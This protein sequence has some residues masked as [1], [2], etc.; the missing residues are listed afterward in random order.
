MPPSTDDFISLMPFD[1]A[2]CSWCHAMLGWGLQ[3]SGYFIEM[4]HF[5]AAIDIFF[6][7][8]SAML[9]IGLFSFTPCFRRWPWLVY[10]R[11]FSILPLEASPLRYY[12]V[13]LSLFREAIVAWCGRRYASV[14][15]LSL[16]LAAHASRVSCATSPFQISSAYRR[17]PAF[18]PAC[19]SFTTT[20]PP[21]SSPHFSSGFIFA[22]ATAVFF[23]RRRRASHELL[24][25]FYFSFIASINIWLYF[26]TIKKVISLDTFTCW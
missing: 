25:F 16:R 24:M 4:H 6:F 9:F 21:P 7:F 3:L 1:A 12:C 19:R 5:I 11:H 17:L 13:M 10:F 23:R 26:I 22:I 18:F 15:V 14:V 8:F 2:T 20:P